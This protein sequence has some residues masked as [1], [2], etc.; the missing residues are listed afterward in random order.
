MIL[1]KKEISIIEWIR[2]L[3][4]WKN[5]IVIGTDEYIEISKKR[6]EYKGDNWATPDAII[7]DD[8]L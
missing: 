1:S 3:E 6:I 5:M 4:V 8:V 7:V 2:S